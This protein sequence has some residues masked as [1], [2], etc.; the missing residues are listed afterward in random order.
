MYGSEAHDSRDP[1]QGSDQ[2]PVAGSALTPVPR[3]LILMLDGTNNTLTGGVRDTNVL[4]LHEQLAS[5][6]DPDQILYYDP[7][8]GSPDAMPSTG[9]FDSIG[10]WVQRIHGLAYGRGIYENIRDGY[11]F[12]MRNWRPGDQIWLFGF[13]RG[14]FTA[15]SISGMVHLFGILDAQHESMLP[16]LL[17][18]YFSEQIDNVKR[19]AG[20][21]AKDTD[22]QPK[23]AHAKRSRRGV[24]EQIR[25]TFCSGERNVAEVHFVGVWDTV[26]SVGIPMLGV[27]ISSK[28]TVKNKRINHV[29]HALALDELRLTFRPRLYDQPNEGSI[30]DRQ[31]LHQLWFRGVHSDVGGG[32]LHDDSG[33]SNEAYGWMIDEAIQCHLRCGHVVTTQAA[34]TLHDTVHSV[35]WWAI[36]GLTIRRSRWEASHSSVQEHS[37]VGKAPPPVSIWDRPWDSRTWIAVLLALVTMS[38]GYVLQAVALSWSW[39]EPAWS[40]PAELG[41]RPVALILSPGTPL[42]EVLSR[43]VTDGIGWAL[44]ADTLLFLPGYAFLFARLSGWAYRRAAGLRTAAGN[45]D[46]PIWHWLGFCPLVVV[47]GD[48]SENLLTFWVTSWCGPLNYW[49]VGVQWLTGVASASKWLGLCGCGVLALIAIAKL[50][51][52]SVSGPTP[53]RP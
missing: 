8:V 6:N 7:G 35:P 3:Q 14:A 52:K 22:Q 44:V 27:Q 20:S 2:T 39:A 30:N 10:R 51:P 25:G 46:P 28:P 33:L 45:V 34:S 16:T 42:R 17:R 23:A 40:S 11:L 1:T 15:R 37:S 5:Y 24:A 43:H 48:L 36:A 12:L 32:Y 18:V 53:L 4:K 41:S 49:Q 31:S 29:R 47:L 9:L 38:A 26:E 50:K 21:K 19:D 13:S